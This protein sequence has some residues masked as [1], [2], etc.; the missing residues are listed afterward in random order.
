LGKL[1]TPKELIAANV[2]LTGRG[3]RLWERELAVLLGV[4][5]GLVC[6]LVL[7]RVIGLL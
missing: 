4:L 7:L 6:T 5:V 1:L 2:V 3:D